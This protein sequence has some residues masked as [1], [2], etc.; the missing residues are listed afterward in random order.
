MS[1]LSD[2][3]TGRFRAGLQSS[4]AGKQKGQAGEIPDCPRGEIWARLAER[5]GCCRGWDLQ[6]CVP[7]CKLLVLSL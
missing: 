1:V 6:E 7:F 2:V 4:G 3:S 5:R